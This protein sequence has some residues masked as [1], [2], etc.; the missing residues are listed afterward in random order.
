MEFLW[1]HW[2][3]VKPGYHWGFKNAHLPK[4]GFV[5]ADSGAVFGFLDPSLVLCACHLISAFADGHT[6]SLLCH[7]AL[8]AQENN[9]L[10]NWAAYY[11]NM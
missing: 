7:G 11:V 1:V 2:F 4:I 9:N 3:G 5:P 6:D 8:V 10:N